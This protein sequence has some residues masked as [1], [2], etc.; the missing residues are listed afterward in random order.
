MKKNVLTRYSMLLWSCAALLAAQLT[1]SAQTLAHEY[2]FWNDA[3]GTT[4]A[5]DVIGG[6]NGTL[7]GSAA[8]L[9]GQLQLDGT[10]GTYV[11]LQPGIVTNDLAVTVEAWG[12]WPAIGSQGIWAN[13]F[14]FG[15]R[16]PVTNDSYS[17]SFCVYSGNPAGTLVAGISDFDNA[18]VN[19][20]NVN[21]DASLIGNSTPGTYVAVVFN[22]TNNTGSPGAGY[23]AI[24]VNGVLEASG[25]IVST[26]TPGVRDVDNKIGFD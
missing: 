21:C 1:A 26:I 8:I 10:A 13:L 7:M 14:D 6:N 23:E 12:L 25:P 18:N 5:P 16:D 4:N 20:E 24:Y 19:R 9:G 22:P 3:D 2:S 15:T 11:A 17:I